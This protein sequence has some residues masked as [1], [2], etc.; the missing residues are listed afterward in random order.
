MTPE[1]ASRQVLEMLNLGYVQ[2]AGTVNTLVTTFSLA[3]VSD[4]GV[5]AWVTI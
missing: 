2:R 5:W 3:L 4:P 1:P